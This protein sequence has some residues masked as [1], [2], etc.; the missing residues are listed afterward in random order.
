MQRDFRKIRGIGA[1]TALFSAV[2]APIACANLGNLLLA[3][4]RNK[5]SLFLPTPKSGIKMLD[6]GLA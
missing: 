5:N 2:Y 3:R 1:N 6:F 4:A